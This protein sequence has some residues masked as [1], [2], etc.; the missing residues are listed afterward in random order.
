MKLCNLVIVVIVFMCL[1]GFPSCK[2]ATKQAVGEVTEETTEKAIKELTEEATE[3]WG[4]LA[5]QELKRLDWSDLMKVIK[6]NDL[7][8]YDAL[9]RLDK[10]FQKK[11][12]QAF[13]I[14]YRFY[15]ALTSSRS[16]IDEFG[17]VAKDAPSV[18]KDIN[19]FRYFVKKVDWER[20]NG[21]PSLFD[22]LLLKEDAG[23]VKFIRRSDGKSLAD[24]LDGVVTVQ[25][26]EALKDFVQEAKLIPN[27]LYK[28]RGKEGLSYLF[29]ADNL[30]RLSK[31]E[32]SAIDLDDL[33]SKVLQPHT[34]TN[35]GDD[36]ASK[37]KTISETSRGRDIKASALFRYIDDETTPFAAK[38]DVEVGNKTIIAQSYSNLRK[39]AGKVFSAE[40]N[41]TLLDKLSSPL[42]LSNKKK[43]DLL[44]NMNDDEELA[45]MIHDNPEF[46]IKRWL[47]TR[48]H[49][50]K[51]KI[52]RTA[53]GR[54]VPNGRIYAGNTY[55]FNPH[56]NPALME[57]L[58]K[59]N[60]VINLK[61]FGTLSY[62][63]LLKLDKL[64]PDGVPFTKEGY[65]DFTKVAFKGKDGEVLKIN[66]GSLSG[67]SKK[68]I[69][70]AETMFQ[71]MGYAWEDGYTWHHIENSTMLIRVPRAIHQLVD[72]AGGMS[73]HIVQE[74]VRQAA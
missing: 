16:L 3:A 31:V 58:R 46:N 23:L 28:M 21:L 22:D 59:G 55:S 68:D 38:I 19:L 9:N 53:G 14:D 72:H 57:R 4:N 39:V 10:G 2:K 1:V 62:D 15:S 66:I 42:G 49:V 48:N 69:S 35:F 50:N 43:R 56:L 41:A 29:Y 11:L 40:E 32:A 64:Y 44:Q 30:G 37:L 47:N 52:A 36:F 8:M 34:T 65:P 17:V 5:Q 6:K 61:N 70:I 54:M 18:T 24:Y 51:A 25:S 71:E 26:P 7:V 63:D 74:L 67:D 20:R 33:V 45:R 13:K 12:T 27:A 73:T 60:G